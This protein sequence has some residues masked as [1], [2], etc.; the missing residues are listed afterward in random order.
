MLKSMTGYGRAQGSGAG[1]D[2]TVELKSV[3]HRYFECA[4]RLPK[5]F[6]FLEDSL[7]KQMQAAVSRGKT[8]IQL[9]MTAQGGQDT[10]VTVDEEALLRCLSALRAAG[11]R[12]GLTDDLALSDVIRLPDLFTVHRAEIDEEAAAAAVSAVM[13]EA[14]A[15]FERMRLAE[16][17]KLLEDLTGRLSR[18]GELVGEI[19]ACAPQRQK[20]YYDRLYAKVSELLQDA[21]V[22]ES[23]LITEAAIFADKVAVD[24]ETVRLRSHLSQFAGMLDA[25]GPAGKKLDFLVQEM[26]REANT[27]GSKA[28]DAGMA[29]I[30]VEIKSEIE[31]IRE[32][33]QNIE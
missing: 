28:Q 30:V 4:V 15:A 18:I 23:R 8:E 26:N 20:A 19:E 16:G 27:I 32:Q 11:E 33:I 14:I 17:E 31:K 2:I 9:T 21:Q 29:R 1:F 6:S 25:G 3:N 10:V 12:A 22:D 13:E 24:E 7:K 5:A